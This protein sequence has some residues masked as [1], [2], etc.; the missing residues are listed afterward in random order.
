[1]LRAVA[2]GTERS[3]SGTCNASLFA[4]L[5]AQRVIDRLFPKSLTATRIRDSVFRW[6]GKQYLS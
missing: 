3:V 2:Y 1:V 4:G 6:A 5:A